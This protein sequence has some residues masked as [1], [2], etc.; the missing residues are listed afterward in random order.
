MKVRV[1]VTPRKE[2]LD[3]QGKAVEGALKRLGYAEVSSVRVGKNIEFELNE[4]DRKK[5]SVRVDEMCKKL[6]SNPIIEDARYELT[7]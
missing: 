3:P 5:A 2:V 6:L 4:K 1:V 7:E